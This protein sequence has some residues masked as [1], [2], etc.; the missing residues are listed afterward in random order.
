MWVGY[1]EVGCDISC[2]VGYYLVFVICEIMCEDGMMVCLLDFVEF[3]SKYGFK[4]GMILDLIFYCFCNDNL[5]E[6]IDCCIV[7]LEFGGEWDMY[8]F[9]D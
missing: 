5:V 3:F 2:F 6:L 8:I 7:D 9:I 1:I 4:I